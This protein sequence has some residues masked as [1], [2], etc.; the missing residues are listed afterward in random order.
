[1]ATPLAENVSVY[2]DG[3]VRTYIVCGLE[4]SEQD[5]TSLAETILDYA[6]RMLDLEADDPAPGIG[7]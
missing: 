5:A 3:E 6:G 2:F 4:M 1:M 7:I